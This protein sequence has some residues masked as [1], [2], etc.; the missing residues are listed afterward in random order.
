MAVDAVRRI[1]RGLLAG[2][3]LLAPMPAVADAIDEAQAARLEDLRRRIAGEVQLTV[4]ELLD[5]L[6]YHWKQSPPFAAETPVVLA[7]VTVP[8]GLGTGL[9]GLVENHLAGLLLSNPDS[10]VAL[11]HC[12][13]CTA[14][15]VHSGPKGTVVSRGLDNPEVLARVGGPGGRHGLHLDVAAE[16]AW[17]VLRAR[18]TRLT[19]DL[20][21]VWSRTL[22]TAA[23]APSLLRESDHLKS[24]AEARLEHREALLQRGPL[25]V[26][27]RFS[28]RTYAAPALGFATRILETPVVSPP[29]VLW[30]QTGLEL[31]LTQA[32]AWNASFLFGFAFVPEAYDGLMVQTRMSRLISGSARSLDGPDVYLFLGGALMTL[33]GLAVGPFTNGDYAELV[34]AT[35]S[36]D[37]V[38]ATFGAFHIGLEIRVGERIGASV[39]LENMPAYAESETVGDFMQTPFIDFQSLGAEVSFSF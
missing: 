38:R 1:G 23:G 34:A 20:P 27:I 13:S 12:P 26:P 24:A 7:D 19:P 11:S 5:E 17:L 14:V 29:P 8:V 36:P 2:I 39:F 9:V 25:T 37:E 4:F 21:I 15:V 30:I 10:R 6:V 31:A 3:V 33:Q 35:S 28:V 32:R 22:T 16:G 18:I